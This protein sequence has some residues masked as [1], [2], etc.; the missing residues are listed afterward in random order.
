MIAFNLKKTMQKFN[1]KKSIS[2]KL[3]LLFLLI[4][5]SS[6]AIVSAL[7]YYSSSR[8]LKAQLLNN[9]VS[10]AESRE[11]AILNFLKLHIQLL[12]VLAA[13]EPLQNLME[14]FNRKEQ[15]EKID[16]TA[17]QQRMRGFLETELPEFVNVTGFYDYIC[18]GKRGKVYLATERSLIG[19]DY[20]KDERFGNGMKKPYL[21]DVYF[22]PRK[23]SYFRQMTVPIFA[24][25]V[26]HQEPIGVIVAKTRTDYLEEI[27]TNREG[28]GESGEVYVV[29]RDGLMITES[30]FIKDTILK[31]KVDT[32][33]VRLF[34]AQKKIMAGVYPNY[35]GVPVAGASMGDD[36]AREFPE[37]G[38]TI[39]AEIDAA[40]FSLPIIK[41]R[42]III[43]V[44]LLILLITTFIALFISNT[45]TIP[46]KKLTQYARK[47]KEEGDL[48]L[49]ISIGSADEIGILA[50]AFKAMVDN[51]RNAQDRIIRSERLSAIGQLASSVAHELR[52]PLFVMKNAVYYLN[53]LG[54]GKDNPDIRKNMD[55]IASE[56][57]NSDKIISDLLEFGRIKKPDLK[58]EEIN[59][60]IQETLDRVKAPAN[61]KVVME[62]GENLPQIWV[63]ALQMQQT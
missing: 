12:E 42:N 14:E 46:I 21:S 25:E 43:C 9:L 29:N 5:F 18:I 41:L 63:D 17:L 45:I 35:R 19:A 23:K 40:E 58:P 1:F 22:D 59:L 36:I 50:N 34:Q 47:I 3:V 60:I 33:P 31:Q 56:I 32:V 49:D 61:I 16:E 53:M 11:A 15:G 37:L 54:S 30:R 6:I 28:L 48:N 44:A 4:S 24:H 38:W 10:I 51:L 2:A 27:T 13:N 52:N 62:L 26:L 7:S 20:S 39:L 8:A 57:E 55:I